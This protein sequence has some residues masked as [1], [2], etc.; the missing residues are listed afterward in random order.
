MAART[1][2]NC[3][4]SQALAVQDSWLPGICTVC[5]ATTMQRIGNCN[6]NS[7]Q[8]SQLSCATCNTVCQATKQAY[9]SIDH[10]NIE[11]HE[12]V[13]KYTSKTPHQCEAKDEFIFRNWTADWWNELQDSYLTADKV[14][15]TKAQDSGV[16]FSDGQAKPDPTNV[17]HPQGSLV[18]AKK[19]N[20]ISD[21]VSKFRTSLAKVKGSAEVGCEN[22]DVIRASHAV[23]L[24]TSYQAAKFKTDVCDCCNTKVQWSVHCS[25][26]CSCSCTCNCSCQCG[27][28]C[29]DR[30]S[31]CGC[32]CSCGCS[33]A[34]IAS[35]Q[36]KPTP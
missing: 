16:S 2:V 4:P 19:Y 17:P 24:R 30:S 13:G 20:E 18:T 7:A 29:S 28:G 23:A 5:N 15:K 22:A 9:C 34:G 21:A 11:D 6:S 26:N 35:P 25:C 32:T 3:Y 12:D 27:C 1:Q 33:A 10:E 8:T 36:L 14:G 31:G